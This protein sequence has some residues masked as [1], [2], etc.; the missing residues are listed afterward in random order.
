VVNAV[1]ASMRTPRVVVRSVG[2]EHSAQMPL[3][4]DQQSVGELDPD[5]Q[6]E[7]FGEAVRPRTPGRDLD[8]LDTRIGEHCV[9]RGRELSRAVADEEPEPGRFTSCA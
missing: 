2:R 1:A 5:S 4:E 6:H 9:E 3:A 8:H 7:P